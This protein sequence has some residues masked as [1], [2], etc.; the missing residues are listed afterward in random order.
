ME[1]YIVKDTTKSVKFDNIPEYAIT[2]LAYGDASGLED[3]D[4]KTID[5]WCREN[6]I[7]HLTNTGEERHF[8]SHPEFG[9]AIDCVE[10]TF[11]VNAKEVVRKEILDLDPTGVGDEK[12]ELVPNDDAVYNDEEGRWEMEEDTFDWWKEVADGRQAAY[13][14]FDTEEEYKDFINWFRENHNEVGDEQSLANKENLLK[15]I[16]EYEDYKIWLTE[17]CAVVFYKR[18]DDTI[19]NCCDYYTEKFRSGKDAEN[20]LYGHHNCHKD[21]VCYH[22][23]TKKEYEDACKES[24]PANLRRILKQPEHSKE[25]DILLSKDAIVLGFVSPDGTVTCNGYPR[26]IYHELEDQREYAILPAD[27]EGLLPQNIKH[28]AFIKNIDEALDVIRNIER[29]ETY[30]KYKQFRDKPITELKLSTDYELLDGKTYDPMSE[31]YDMPTA[32]REDILDAIENNGNLPGVSPLYEGDT[33]YSTW[34]TDEEVLS[35]IGYTRENISSSSAGL[36]KAGKDVERLLDFKDVQAVIPHKHE[37][38]KEGRT[39]WTF[40]A[41]VKDKNS[42]YPLHVYRN[43]NPDA[44]WEITRHIGKEDTKTVK[45]SEMTEW[46]SGNGIPC[47]GDMVERKIGGDWYRAEFFVESNHGAK[48]RLMLAA[49]SAIEKLVDGRWEKVTFDNT[50]EGDRKLNE[51]LEKMTPDVVDD[52]EIDRNRDDGWER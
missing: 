10:A 25:K 1:I 50:E 9:L 36:E 20:W 17:P 19:Y 46:A 7:D 14:Y 21:C 4:I 43:T 15:E 34:L 16:K 26:N 13:D 49:D 37:I 27:Y 45:L 12:D 47:H 2:Y 28:A 44:M 11:L 51:L 35:M 48:P 39:Y 41:I 5:K 6:D 8:S 33:T 29:D 38:E 23:F 52:R 24:F 3:E 42:L 40:D 30:R 32:L 31:A 18:S 22:K